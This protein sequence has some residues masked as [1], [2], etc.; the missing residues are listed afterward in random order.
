MTDDDFLDEVGGSLIVAIN[1]PGRLHKSPIEMSMMAP[2]VDGASWLDPMN[3]QETFISYYT[4]GEVIAL[5][6]DLT[7]RTQYG[8]TLDDYMRAVWRKFGRNQ[9]ASLAPAR[10]YT[11]ADLQNELALLTNDRTFAA[12]FFKRYVQGNEV[13]DL[14]AMLARAGLHL[15]T[16]TSDKPYL[17]ASLD[18]DSN[19][20]FVNWSAVN[21]SAYPAGL[22]SGD[23]VYEID[24]IAV[25]TPDSL[26]AVIARHKVGDVVKLHVN[27]REQHNLLP[28]RL[29]GR[30]KLTVQTYEKA[31][32]PI[33]AEIQAFRAAWLGSKVVIG[34]IAK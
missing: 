9:T 4:W 13:P 2:F 16:E 14:T 20:V 33:T 34:A 30:P 5:S 22:S 11:T 29:V 7:L 1:S 26:N 23:L 25:N 27:Q 17:G 32:L 6:L 8:T 31:G 28:M 19:F 10:P 18:K 15:R 24:G 21:G 12:A 3:S